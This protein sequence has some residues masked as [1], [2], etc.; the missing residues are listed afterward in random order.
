MSAKKSIPTLLLLAVASVS[1]VLGVDG[2]QATTN[3]SAE[4]SNNQINIQGEGECHNESVD[5]NFDLN[6]Q[7]AEDI[8]SNR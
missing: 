8:C 2:I 5:S 1:V 7:S 3:A 6:G 4:E